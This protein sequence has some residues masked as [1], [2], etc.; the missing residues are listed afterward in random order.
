[1]VITQTPFRI[2]LAGGGTD[3]RACYRRGYGAVVTTTI[4][5][6]VYLAIHRFFEPKIMLKY[7]QTEVVNRTDEIKHPLIR[8][9]LKICD[10]DEPLDLTSFADIPSYGSGLG[11]SSA[12]G[13]GLIKALHGFCCREISAERCAKLTC[14]AEIERLNEPIGKQD[15]YATAFGGL[16]YIRFNADESVFVEPIILPAR[17]HELLQNHLVLFYTHIT[18]SARDILAEQQQNTESDE[19]TARR[20]DRLRELA[21]DPRQELSSGNVAAV[22]EALH[23]S[24]MLKKQLASGISNSYLDAMYD[25]ARSSGAVGGKILGAGGGGFFLFCCPP[26]KQPA[27]LKRMDGLRRVPFQ[28]EPQG[29]RTIYYHE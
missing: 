11:S 14:E 15:Q 6:F 18:R 23:E 9:C 1:M 20:L 28:F 27:L 19:A 25:A 12:F 17:Q 22:G 10:V 21:D 26:E 13:V 2:S 7:S 5:K 29:T 8:E 3:L 4:D 24:W 16:N